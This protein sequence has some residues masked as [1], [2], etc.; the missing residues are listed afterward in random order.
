M[1]TLKQIN[2]EYQRLLDTRPIDPSGLDYGIAERHIS[3]LKILE[4]LQGNCYQIFDM[5]AR[6]HIYA[7]DKFNAYFGLSESESLD[8]RTHPDDLYRMT[9]LG[10]A[11]VG[12]VH[13]VPISERRRYKLI[14]DFRIRR[15]DGGYGRV[16]KQYIAM[17]LAPDGNLWLTLCT[18]STSVETDINAPL[19]SRLVHIETGEVLHVVVKDGVMAERSP[20]SERELE[21]LELIARGYSSKQIASKLFV[22]V[23]TVNTHRQNMMRRIAMKN[24]AEVVKHACDLGLLRLG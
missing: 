22:S 12:F 9:E 18:L 14:N 15:N 6:R 2:A 23:H 7:T 3:S 19:K 20:F 17:E 5:H 10:L 11:Y 8:D 13:S 16:S 4:K 21:I 1:K 24:T